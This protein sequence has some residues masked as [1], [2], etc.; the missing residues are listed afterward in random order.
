MTWTNEQTHEPLAFE[1]R[2]EW[3]ELLDHVLTEAIA[4]WLW[5]NREPVAGEFGRGG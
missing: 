3:T 2:Q 1:H 5:M 4:K